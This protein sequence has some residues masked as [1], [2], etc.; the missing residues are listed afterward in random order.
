MRAW[1][2]EDGDERW[3]EMHYTVVDG[4]F[5]AKMIYPEQIDP[6]E[7]DLER[8]ARIVREKF[9]DKPIDYPDP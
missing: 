7:D 6:Q 3:A 5:K 9:G 1:D 2:A 4:R 8:R